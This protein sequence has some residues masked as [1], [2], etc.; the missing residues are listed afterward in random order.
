MS[1]ARKGTDRLEDPSR[2]VRAASARSLGRAG[3]VSEPVLDA[4]GERLD[5][6]PLVRLIALQSLALLGAEP[7]RVLPPL[8]EAL[9]GPDEAH[10]ATASY[11]LAQM[12][13]NARAA[14]P[15]LMDA[16]GDESLRVRSN[17]AV[18]L[19]A[20]DPSLRDS[21]P[22]LRAILEQA[23]AGSPF[24]PGDAAVPGGNSA[25]DAQHRRR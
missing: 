1:Y 5:D 12:G 18:A 10:R 7:D 25:L 16:L 21:S 9:R 23:S 17:A 11:T 13:E 2:W 22:E 6:E 15:A 24:G 3:P 8:L 4:L 14:L 19:D 20:L